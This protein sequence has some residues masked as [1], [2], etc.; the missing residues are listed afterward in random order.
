MQDYQSDCMIQSDHLINN[1]FNFI[2]DVRG[3]GIP[4]GVNAF[5]Y[6]SR[7]NIIATG[8]VD[9]VIRVWH[10]HIFSRPTGKLHETN[11]GCNSI[12]DS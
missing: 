12:G 1:V 3:V 10:P 9:K 6:C 11:S 5:D 8:G 7:A 4:K 2:R